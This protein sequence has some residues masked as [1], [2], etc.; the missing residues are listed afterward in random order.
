MKR[1]SDEIDPVKFPQLFYLLWYKTDVITPW[2][3]LEAY[4][5]QWRFVN[6]EMMHNDERLLL[7]ELIDELSC[8]VFEPWFDEQ[9]H[10]RRPVT[11]E[12]KM[13]T[14][15]ELM[16]DRTEFIGPP[17]PSKFQVKLT[18][19]EE[20]KLQEFADRM[21]SYQMAKRSDGTSSD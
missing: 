2:H 18:A 10:D 20:Q 13:M 7:I 6:Y 14:Y 4:K 11:I 21:V 1:R 17:Q 16:E 3:A 5:R 15:E 19:A 9:G 8:G 12:M